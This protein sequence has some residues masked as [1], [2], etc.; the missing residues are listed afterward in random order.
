MPRVLTLGGGLMIA[1]GA[2]LPWLSLYG[3]L[4]SYPGITGLYG[5]VLLVLGVVAVMVALMP[6]PKARLVLSASLIGLGITAAILAATR[7]THTRALVSSGEAVM[8]VPSVGPGLMV[9]LFGSALVVVGGLTRLR[10]R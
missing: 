4:H 1:A 2:L 8:L 7:L 10:A 9:V 5:R 6:A 3:G